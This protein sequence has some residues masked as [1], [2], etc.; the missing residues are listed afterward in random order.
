MNDFK[1]IEN[2]LEKGK[3]DAAKEKNSKYR[4]NNNPVSCLIAAKILINEKKFQ[5]AEIEISNQP[6]IIIKDSQKR[7]EIFIIE[8]ILKAQ[9][10]A[11][12]GEFKDAI[13]DLKDLKERNPKV[14]FFDKV[15]NEIEIQAGKLPQK[16]ENQEK[17]MFVK[18]YR[19]NFEVVAD[20]NWYVVSCEWFI[21]WKAY[22]E[23][24]PS[25]EYMD[26]P[27]NSLWTENEVK[28]LERIDNTSIIDPNATEDL[29]DTESSPS[30]YTV[31]SGLIENSDFVL[32][33]EQAYNLLK[34]QYSPK[35]Y[36]I[37]KSIKSSETDFLVEVFLKRIRFAYVHKRKVEIKSHNTSRTTKLKAIVELLMKKLNIATISSNYAKIKVW[38]I[39]SKSIFE[40]NLKSLLPVNTGL[41]IEGSTLLAQETTIDDAEISEDNL[42]F[43]DQNF[44][45]NFVLSE[46]KTNT[47]KL[48]SV[49]KKEFESTSC[50]KCKA[51]VCSQS[52]LSVHNK[53]HNKTPTKTRKRA[54]KLRKNIFRCFCSWNDDA[55]ETED[56]KPG[57]KENHQSVTPSVTSSSLSISNTSSGVCGL[58]NLGNTCFM[59]SAVQCLVHCEEL[60]KFF[61]SGDYLKKINKNNPLGTKGRLAIA[62]GELAAS[63]W[64]GKHTSLAPWN[65]K[66]TISSVAPQFEGYSQHDSHEFLSYLINGLHED[67]NEVT[68][69]PYYDTEITFTNDKEVAE[70][71]W[72][73]HVSRNKSIIVDLMYGQYKSTL[74]CPKCK[75]YSYA[76]D[77][78][79]CLSL[80]IP[81]M[82]QK[83]I[84][85]FYFPHDLTSSIK[86]FNFLHDSNTTLYDI[87]AQLSDRIN[88]RVE[89]LQAFEYKNSSNIVMVQDQQKVESFKFIS[90][91]I[92]ELE[93]QTE[94]VVMLTF[95]IENTSKNQ[96]PRILEVDKS[97]SINKLYHNALDLV[98]FLLQN[99]SDISTESFTIWTN[100]NKANPCL[101]CNKLN[102]KGCDIRKSQAKIQSLFGESKTLFLKLAFSVPLKKDMISR[103]ETF[104]KVKS[105]QNNPNLITIQ[106]CFRAF[107]HPEV[108]DKNNSWYCPYC[109]T[110][111]QAI[112]KLEIYEVPKILIIHLK[113]FKTIGY[114]RDKVTV[115]IAFLKENLDI[116]EYVIGHKP[117]L[118]DLYAVSNHFGTLTGGHYTATA[119]HP[120]SGKWFECNDSSISETLEIS[121][122]SSYVLFY[123]AKNSNK[124]QI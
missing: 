92:Y 47:L 124:I 16:P 29:V 61:L 48:C 82:A 53:I 77:P 103:L 31:S 17:E 24:F 64:S 101:F 69:K 94:N 115:P 74:N 43:F 22:V 49:C 8:A 11:G 79:N 76:F 6:R 40:G 34:S 86:I 96:Y 68:K 62:Y 21:K 25:K 118:Y 117:D 30:F 58:Q 18:L 46:N 15:L 87:K 4:L 102:C 20:S 108:L 90:I 19:E 113:R 27:F 35:Q 111:V 73:R 13:R 56:C 105:P 104:E 98:Q 5:E 54:G 57:F 55:S 44:S 93:A 81:Y 1:D 23:L 85:V 45:D 28:K 38:K 7:H 59:N 95:S 88:V 71:N 10:K 37:R 41:Y 14:E 63:M 66:K 109:K 120:D 9:I 106:D 100:P 50:K 121:E 70:E 107:S 84:E 112:K 83:K 33:P 60:T 52:C 65:L 89:N 51:C 12:K 42:L 110:H 3:L 122:T 80:P 67:L 26:L 2:L 39:N 72:R 97:Y 99:S 114:H 78:Y 116:S 32:I 36:I 119:K 91:Y 123:K 75:K